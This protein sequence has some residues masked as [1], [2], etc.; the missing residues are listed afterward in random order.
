MS[1]TNVA[2]LGVLG[3]TLAASF[4]AFADPAVVFDMGDGYKSLCENMGGVYLDG[5]SLKFNPFAN[6]LDDAH[7]DLSAERIRDQMSVMASP[8][9]DTFLIQNCTDIMWVD[10]LNGKRKYC[11]FMFGRTN[12]FHAGNCADQFGSIME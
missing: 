8:N 12:D 3:L 2:R 6:I 11:G 7:F 1:F 9:G 4:Q 5:D 10:S